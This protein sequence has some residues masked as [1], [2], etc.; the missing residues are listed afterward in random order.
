MNLGKDTLR[1]LYLL[2]KNHPHTYAHSLKVTNYSLFLGK[3]MGLSNQD[4]EKLK[5]ASLFHDIGK[6]KIPTNILRKPGKLTDEE[7]SLVKKHV[8]F[9]VELLINSGFTDLEIL[10][11]IEAHHER[12]DGSGYPNSLCENDIPFLSKIISV[13]DAY[14]A[15]TSNRC[16]RKKQN[17][18]YARCEL[19]RGIGKQ[20]DIE[21]TMSFIQLLD[22]QLLKENISKSLE[23]R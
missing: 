20:F 12:I 10:K 6:L 16:Y 14:D 7:Y 17:F 8:E 2:K 3:N 15:M 22:S 9:S 11:I 4:L 1:L 19:L 5:I 13:V 23:E 18:N 21:I